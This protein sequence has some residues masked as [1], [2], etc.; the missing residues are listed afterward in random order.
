MLNIFLGSN[1]WP[2]S[3]FKKLKE[4]K[5]RKAQEEFRLAEEA[6]QKAIAERKTL[7]NTY[8]EYI[9]DIVTTH[10]KDQAQKR[11][12][13]IDKKEKENKESNHKCPRCGCTETIEVFRRSKG[14]LNGSFSSSSSSSYSHSA[15]LFT[16]RGYGESSHSSRGDI[17][18][19]LDT[20]KVNRCSKCENEWEI[21]PEV[22]YPSQVDFFVG[23]EDWDTYAKYFI[24]DVTTLIYKIGKFDP[25]QLD[26]KFNSID[27]I[28]EDAKNDLWY[29]RV[30]DWS[31]ELLYYMAYQNKY[32]IRKKEEVFDEYHYNDG[33]QD[34]LGN[35]EPKFEAFLI[36]HFGFKKHFE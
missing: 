35:F 20:L 34:Y 10:N 28:I 31:L 14:E 16:S 27:E 9:D 2:F 3:Y 30:K 17:K 12:N 22:I 21:L 33:G 36:E 32:D 25:N 11:N 15:C 26:N 13:Y 29:R 23:E 4:E 24:N 8:K 6:K 7:Y 18:G 1:M 19:S 5:I